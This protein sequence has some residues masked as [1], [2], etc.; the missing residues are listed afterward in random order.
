[1]LEGS[2]RSSGHVTMTASWTPA[3]AALPRG[4][5]SDERFL[6]GCK[7]LDNKRTKTTHEAQSLTILGT[8]L[9]PACSWPPFAPVAAGF[10]FPALPR[11][12]ILSHKV[13]VQPSRRDNINCSRATHRMDTAV[14]WLD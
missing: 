6:Y 5:R 4:R 14:D 9:T 8:T 3:S 1:M 12:F 7:L 11:G 10:S 13:Y 2:S